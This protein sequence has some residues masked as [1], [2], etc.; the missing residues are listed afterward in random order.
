MIALIYTRNKTFSLKD[1]KGFRDGL[2]YS[3]P[4][5]SEENKGKCHY[6]ASVPS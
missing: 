3:T 5:E 4:Q 1:K 6:P 2:S